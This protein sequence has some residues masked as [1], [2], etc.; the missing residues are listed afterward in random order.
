VESLDKMKLAPELKN[1]VQQIKEIT[2]QIREKIMID[3][4]YNE[5]MKFGTPE[6]RGHEWLKC[7]LYKNFH[8]HTSP[9][10]YD[11]FT[12][13]GTFIYAYGDDGPWTDAL[14]YNYLPYEQIAKIVKEDWNDMVQQFGAASLSVDDRAKLFTM[15]VL[16]AVEETSYEPYYKA[17]SPTTMD[18]IKQLVTK[19]YKFK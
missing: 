2:K 16:Y 5:I 12:N 11:N 10:D 9:I 19:T 17:R 18:H 3:A 8:H 1:H 14:T 15:M 6:Q 4:A 7:M 13:V